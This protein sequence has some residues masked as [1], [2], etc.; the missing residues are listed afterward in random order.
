MA[1]TPLWESAFSFP[2][3]NTPTLSLGILRICIPDVCCSFEITILVYHNRGLIFV[4]EASN[5]IN[6]WK[7]WVQNC[8]FTNQQ[9]T[10]LDCGHVLRY[11]QLTCHH[12][13]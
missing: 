11:P 9:V 12:D 4:A 2:V 3:I 5:L 7:T 13:T 6:I 1:M 10:S 8:Q